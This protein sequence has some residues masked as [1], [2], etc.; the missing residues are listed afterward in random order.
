MTLKDVSNG[1][2]W[3]I[4][5]VFA[6]ILLMSIVMITG[7][8]AGLIAGYNTAS[9]EE[10]SKYNEKKLCRITGAGMSVMAVFILI[11]GLAQ[12]VLPAM[13]AYIFLAV[14]LIDCVVIIILSNT[15][16]KR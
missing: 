6:I 11:M 1:P 2:E 5:V 3:I 4:W 8:G 15:I 10:K 12:D 16:C 7:R 13:F 14:I 9:K